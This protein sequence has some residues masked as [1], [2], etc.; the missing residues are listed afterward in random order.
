MGG[1]SFFVAN[2]ND[3]RTSAD[4]GLASILTDRDI[5]SHDLDFPNLD[6]YKTCPPLY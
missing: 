6:S 1:L 2:N 5:D 3:P 4:R